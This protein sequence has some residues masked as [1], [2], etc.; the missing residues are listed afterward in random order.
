MPRTNVKDSS[1]W[2]K[3]MYE[4]E[5]LL[6]GGSAHIVENGIW[7]LHWTMSL[8]NESEEIEL[9]QNITDMQDMAT[10]YGYLFYIF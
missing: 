7:P 8:N 2:K 6:P 5:I 3:Y 4:G 9:K 10:K 1:A